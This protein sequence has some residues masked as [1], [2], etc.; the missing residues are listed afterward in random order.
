MMLLACEYWVVEAIPTTKAVI[1][2]VEKVAG[3]ELSEGCDS[4]IVVSVT[5]QA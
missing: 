1:K 4:Q 2:A 5:E 3:I